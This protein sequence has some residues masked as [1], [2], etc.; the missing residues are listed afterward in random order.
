MGTHI[1]GIKDMAGTMKPAAAKLLIGSLRTR[2]PD[3]PIHVHSH[4]SAGTAVASMTACA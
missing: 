4:D 1:L 2:Y 3:L